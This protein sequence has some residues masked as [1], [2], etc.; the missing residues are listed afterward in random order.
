MDA[1]TWFKN[2]PGLLRDAMR[3][4]YCYSQPPNEPDEACCAALDLDATPNTEF[5][6]A[7]EEMSWAWHP[8]LRE[9]A[10]AWREDNCARKWDPS[11]LELVFG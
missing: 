5:Q 2:P 1:S 9:A 8:R 11:L 3:L 4:G 7:F 10:R 6:W